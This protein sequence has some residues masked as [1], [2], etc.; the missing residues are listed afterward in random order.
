MSQTKLQTR[1]LNITQRYNGFRWTFNNSTAASDPG[2]GQFGFG[3]SSYGG[4]SVGYFNE[5]DADG[6]AL[7]S[8]IATWDDATLNTKRGFLL[9]QSTTNVGTW[10]LFAVNGAVTDGGSWD[11]VAMTNI[12]GGTFPV[13]GEIFYVTFTPIGGAILST[14][15]L[16]VN[17]GSLAVKIA[18]SSLV[19]AAGG[20]SVQAGGI[21]AAKMGVLTTKGDIMTYS[22]LHVRMGVGSNNQVLMCDSA[23]TN[24]IKWGDNSRLLFTNATSGTAIAN[25]LT[26][27]DFDQ[28]F[29]LIANAIKSN[30]VLRV[31]FSG[32]YGTTG[33]P[34]V[35]F[36]LKL[37]TT[38][39]INTGTLPPASGASNKGWCFDA[40]IYCITAGAS[41]TIR[42]DLR[43]TFNGVND[44]IIVSGDVTGVDTTTAATLKL[45]GQWDTANAS[46]TIR[47][48]VAHTE[49]CYQ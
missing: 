25:T 21:S 11:S 14:G 15:G 48:L 3:A 13:S 35:T 46:N 44:F 16:E 19:T 31:K 18:D 10:A 5:T 30:S 2:T 40:N 24:G 32:S 9:Y 41:A 47:T 38:T 37:G 22:T 39:L 29:S 20:L 4:I 42:Y 27:T 17:S 12:A 26:E 45:T 1:Q 49:I 6:N 34:N 23:Q 33:T 7:A 43:M 8:V 28:N 36:K